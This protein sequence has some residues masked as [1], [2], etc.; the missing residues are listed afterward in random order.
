MS[1]PETRR[2][3]EDAVHNFN[4]PDDAGDLRRILDHMGYPD[5]IE[6]RFSRLEDVASDVWEASERYGLSVDEMQQVQ[7]AWQLL[8]D[9]I[10]DAKAVAEKATEKLG[11]QALDD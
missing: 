1:D 11:G 4:L 2:M 7:E 3:V 5:E 9:R 6:A 10:D 8:H